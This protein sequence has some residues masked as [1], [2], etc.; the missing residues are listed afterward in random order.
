MTFCQRRLCAAGQRLKRAEEAEGGG[1]GLVD[2]LGFA[3]AEVAVFEE[4][5]LDGKD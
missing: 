5:E 1:I 2:G 4:G 3:A